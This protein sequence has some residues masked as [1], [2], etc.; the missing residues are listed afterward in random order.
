MRARENV[1]AQA[2]ILCAMDR[3]DL[4]SSGWLGH[5]YHLLL[6]I[7]ADSYEKLEVQGR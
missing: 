1:A 3:F 4:L 5:D 6:V 7:H 2:L